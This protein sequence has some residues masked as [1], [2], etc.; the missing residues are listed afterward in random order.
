MRDDR[1]ITSPSPLSLQKGT[2]RLKVS[3]ASGY[4]KIEVVNGDVAGHTNMCTTTHEGCISYDTEGK[5]QT[6]LDAALEYVVTVT[7]P[8]TEHKRGHGYNVAAI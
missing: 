7:T 5:C 4:K 8:I 6:Q 3:S 2:Y 1:H